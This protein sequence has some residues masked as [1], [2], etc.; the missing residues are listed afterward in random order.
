MKIVYVAKN[1]YVFADSKIAEE[2]EACTAELTALISRTS[3]LTARQE[4]L[5]ST[6][7]DNVRYPGIISIDKLQAFREFLEER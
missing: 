4:A 5:Q 3:E 1:G 6:A 2:Y 7:L